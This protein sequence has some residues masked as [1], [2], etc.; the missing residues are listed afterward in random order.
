[1][2]ENYKK[3]ISENHLENEVYKW[4][5]VKKYNNCPN[6]DAVDFT[7]EIKDIKFN[8]LIYQMGAAV[9]VH[10]AKE[11]PEELRQL[12]KNLFNENIDLAQRV[13]AFNE[14]TLKLYRDLGETLSHHQDE[15]SISIYLTLHN[16]EKY[17]FY[18]YSFYKKY[19]KFLGVKEANKN[20]KY[21]HYLELINNLIK[22]YII[23]DKELIEQVKNLIPEYYDGSNHNILAQDILYQMFD[24]E[25]EINYWLF[26]GNPKV[27]DFKTALKENILNDW[28]VSAHKKKIKVGDKVVLW[29]SGD[30]SGV[31]LLLK[32]HLNRMKRIHL[33]TI[34]YGRKKIRVN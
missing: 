24:Q 32:L 1:L 10:L 18:K 7:H 22:N 4:K 28:T 25:R 33:Q 29:I 34:T 12:F 16:S 30:Q 14:E 13:K 31:M 19:C 9:I 15:R 3:R 23:P 20:E 5:W 26:Q 27:F 11:R 21:I 8:N 17:T 2:I 6:T